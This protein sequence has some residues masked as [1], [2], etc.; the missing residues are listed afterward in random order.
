[1]LVHV[2]NI[3]DGIGMHA[4][5]NMVAPGRQREVAACHTPPHIDGKVITDLVAQRVGV[6]RFDVGQ[7]SPVAKPPLSDVKTTNVLSAS[8]SSPSLSSTIPIAVSVASTMAA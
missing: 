7:P 5:R 4:R 3:V 6:G 8:L 2:Q 1:M